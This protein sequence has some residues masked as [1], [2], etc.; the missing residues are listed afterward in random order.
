VY[1]YL[2]KQRTIVQEL[3]YVNTQTEHIV[4]ERFLK[5]RLQLDA[6]TSSPTITKTVESI[7]K[8]VRDCVDKFQ[9]PTVQDY[10]RQQNKVVG[11]MIE[12]LD[13]GGP[14]AYATNIPRLISAPSPKYP[15]EDCD[16]HVSGVVTVGMTI[17]PDGTAADIHIVKSVSPT[18]DAAALQ[19]VQQARFEPAHS[20]VS[21]AAI[22]AAATL[23]FNFPAH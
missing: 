21:G 6:K 14:K 23:D 20:D 11:Q 3:I 9:G 15:Q 2:R 8:I 10:V 7:T 1:T 22:S 16:A 5:P 4:V 12:Q 13:Q 19:S 17:R 18:L